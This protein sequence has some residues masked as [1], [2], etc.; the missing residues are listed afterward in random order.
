MKP[1]EEQSIGGSPNGICFF[2][3]SFVSGTPFGLGK[4]GNPRGQPPSFWGPKKK[5]HPS[6]Q[7]W[8]VR[9]AVRMIQT[10]FKTGEVVTRHWLSLVVESINLW[11]SFHWLPPVSFRLP[12]DL[13]F[14]VS[15]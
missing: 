1:C 9:S 4:R 5:T 7:H 8:A 6:A 11:L 3:L 2:L 15:L 14:S 12:F 10:F 13:V